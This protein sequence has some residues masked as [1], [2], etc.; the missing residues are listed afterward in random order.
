MSSLRL[1]CT[2]CAVLLSLLAAMPI[3]ARASTPAPDA[4]GGHAPDSVA[5]KPGD[6]VTLVFRVSNPSRHAMRIQPRI[7]YPAGWRLVTPQAPI[8]ADAGARELCIVRVAVP[9]DAAPGRYWVVLTP[10]PSDARVLLRVDSIAVDVRAYHH[11]EVVLLDAPR[12][13]AAGSAYAATFSV[14]N[15]GNVEAAVT[16]RVAS[17]NDLPTSL[18]SGVVHLRPGASAQVRVVVRTDGLRSRHLLHRLELR[19]SLAA[20]DSVPP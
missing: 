15:S 4:T 9:S 17:G 12:R 7:A 20:R 19:A 5:A 2:G 11:I 14:R 1:A 13:I 3:S 18:D 10:L 8:D 6:G 16:L